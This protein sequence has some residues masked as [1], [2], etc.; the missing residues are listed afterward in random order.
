MI[1]QKIGKLETNMVKLNLVTIHCVKSRKL[2]D[3]SNK[4]VNVYSLM[5]NEI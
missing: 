3:L 2:F 1:K 4:V 5:L